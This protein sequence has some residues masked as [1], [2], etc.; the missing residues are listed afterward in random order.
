ML[1]SPGLS[2]C[3]FSVSQEGE[4]GSRGRSCLGG[5][6]RTLQA[7]GEGRGEFVSNASF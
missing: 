4:G 6:T 3:P 5:Y 7:G 2:M 1:C